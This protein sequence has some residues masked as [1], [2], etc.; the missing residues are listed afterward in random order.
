MTKVMFGKN[1]L[2]AVFAVSGHCNAKR[3]RGYDLCCCAASMMCGILENYLKGKKLK[4]LKIKKD[5]G[6]FYASFDRCGM[7]AVKAIEVL[8][9]VFGGYEL[10]EEIYPSNIYTA[11]G[12]FV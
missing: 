2:K 6:Y 9:A 8:E 1:K 3:V 7:A 11:R 12:E 10:L 5:D 4:N